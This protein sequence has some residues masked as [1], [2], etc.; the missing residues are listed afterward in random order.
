[1]NIKRKLIIVAGVSLIMASSQAHRAYGKLHT[2]PQ[3][4][5]KT[6]TFA[7]VARPALVLRPINLN[8][9]ALFAT[10]K[11][12]LRQSGKVL[13]DSMLVELSVAAKAGASTGFDVIGHTDS[14]ASYKYNQKLSERRA[15]AVKKY[16]VSKG[17]PA[18]M[19]H[20]KGKGET[21]PIATNKTKRGMQLNRRVEIQA[22]GGATLELT[23]K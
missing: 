17:F 4:G 22:A 12:V 21:Q 9:K 10:D 5:T 19:I 14:R 6:K 20:S 7:N 2:H 3:P 13:L 1:M 18:G 15:V 11:A 16:L 23:D 8:S